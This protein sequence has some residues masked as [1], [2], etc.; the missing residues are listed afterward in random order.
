MFDFSGT[1]NVKKILIDHDVVK[2]RAKPKVVYDRVKSE[3]SRK[4]KNK[5]SV[6]KAI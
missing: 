2:S 6:K 4:S 1:N 5:K 3:K